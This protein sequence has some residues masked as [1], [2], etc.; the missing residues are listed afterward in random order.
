MLAAVVDVAF[1]KPS[2]FRSNITARVFEVIIGC[3]ILELNFRKGYLTISRVRNYKVTFFH[4]NRS[5]SI[6][7]SVAA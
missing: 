6:K 7:V 3:W 1:A 2:A 5:R 4:D